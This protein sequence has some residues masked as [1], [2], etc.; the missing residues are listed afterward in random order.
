M[1]LRLILLALPK[2]KKG[3][4]RERGKDVEEKMLSVKPSD[5]TNRTDHTL[6]VTDNLVSG[7]LCRPT[8]KFGT[9]WESYKS[10]TDTLL[11]SDT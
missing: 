5:S 6:T 8:A 10:P 2:K 1:I 3:I 11:P 4:W 7:Q 9:E